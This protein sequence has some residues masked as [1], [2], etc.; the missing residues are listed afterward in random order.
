MTSTDLSTAPE[1]L[2]TVHLF[3]DCSASELRTLVELLVVRC[4]APGQ[5]LVGYLDDSSDVHFVLEGRLRATIYSMEGRETIFRDIAAGEHFGELSAIDERPRSA[6][7]V[8][9]THCRVASMS[10]QDFRGLFGSH[11]SVAA[12]LIGH[13]SGQVRELTERVL[14]LSTWTVRYRLFAE[15]LKLGNYGGD[16][17]PEVVIKNFPTHGEI[18][19]R[20]STHREAVSKELSRLSKEGV[21]KQRGRTMVLKRPGTLADVLEAG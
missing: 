2:R 17:G 14:H 9:L 20:I 15:L 6:A 13:L 18:A 7:V 1:K 16:P 19:S 10:A 12:A 5:E 4:H 3:A 8:A 21:L 11:P